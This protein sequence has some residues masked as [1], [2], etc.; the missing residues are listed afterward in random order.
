MCVFCKI[1]S[2]EAQAR[3]VHSDDDIVAFN[4]LNPQAP[5]HVLIIPRKHIE[6]LADATQADTDLLGKL[7]QVARQLAVTL[8][9]AKTG[10]RVIL[11]TGAGAG[12]SVMHIH[13]HLMGG[14]R[15]RW[16]PG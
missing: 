15:M 14:R 7:L 8:D 16:P 1:V 2:G 12:Q 3:L 11:N 13:A 9:I 4:D 5:T 6:S 10:Y